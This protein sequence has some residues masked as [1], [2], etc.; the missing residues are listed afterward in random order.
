MAEVCDLDVQSEGV[1][2]AA[3]TPHTFEDE[4]AF[5]DVSKILSKKEQ[6][7]TLPHGEVLAVAVILDSGEG[8]GETGVAEEKGKRLWVITCGPCFCGRATSRQVA[9]ER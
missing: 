9:A 5:H 6:D 8:G 4:V 3:V 7:I 1:G 2:I